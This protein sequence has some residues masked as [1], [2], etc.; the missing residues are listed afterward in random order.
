MVIVRV[1]GCIKISN[2]HINNYIAT[3]ASF[4]FPLFIYLF[5]DFLPHQTP[6]IR[7]LEKETINR[8]T[9]MQLRSYTY[10]ARWI[11][12]LYQKH[13]TYISYQCY[14]LHIKIFVLLILYSMSMQHLLKLISLLI[15]KCQRQNHLL[16][17]IGLVIMK[18][19]WHKVRN[20][21]TVHVSNGWMCYDLVNRN[22]N[23]GLTKFGIPKVLDKWECHTHCM[24]YKVGEI[25]A[26]K[27]DFQDVKNCCMKCLV[28]GLPPFMINSKLNSVTC[29]LS[30]V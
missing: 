19:C 25:Q 22:T 29:E 24:S 3:Q 1:I 13:M 16:K 27:R 23:V 26:F 14:G 5:I 6:S 8:N 11:K 12:Q 4:T 30:P 17:L 21:L 10:V 2:Y 28:I 7:N 9:G 18:H 15:M 20:S